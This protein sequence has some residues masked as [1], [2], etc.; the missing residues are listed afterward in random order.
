[1]LALNELGR[2][3]LAFGV[4]H[5]LDAQ[6]GRVV[7]LFAVHVAHALHRLWAGAGLA[8][9]DR[10]RAELRHLLQPSAGVVAV[11][12]TGGAAGGAGRAQR[13][14]EPVLPANDAVAVQR[15]LPR[16]GGAGV[17]RWP[18]AHPGEAILVVQRGLEDLH[19]QLLPI[20]LH[21]LDPPAFV[22]APG[23]HALQCPLLALTGAGHADA[24]ECRRVARVFVVVVAL[25]AGAVD[26]HEGCGQ[27]SDLG[28]LFGAKAAPTAVVVVDVTQRGA[29]APGARKPCALVLRL[30]RLALSVGARHELQAAPLRV[31]HA[32]QFALG[33]A[34]QAQ[35]GATGRHDALELPTRVEVQHPPGR[36]PVGPLPAVAGG[37][38]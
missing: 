14:G 18:P 26:P 4:A 36:V 31:G 22:V 32:Q 16:G 3:R 35:G 17:Q 25:A 24:G 28:G 38:S 5:A 37:R 20:V 11:A 34:L 15:F 9:L 2:L 8:V 30:R 19:L 6:G 29:D 10:H 21:R 33:A 27:G 13:F 7:L 1:M 12:H 23:A